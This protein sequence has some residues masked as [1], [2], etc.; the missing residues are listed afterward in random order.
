MDLVTL[1]AEDIFFH[2]NSPYV[3]E[4][5]IRFSARRLGESTPSLVG[6]CDPRLLKAHTP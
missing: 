1:V 2:A 5:E 3:P 6:N 4:A